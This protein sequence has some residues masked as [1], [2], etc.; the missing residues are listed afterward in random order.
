MND[1]RAGP[2]RRKTLRHP[3]GQQVGA[4]EPRKAKVPNPEHVRPGRA[5]A[6]TTNRRGENGNECRTEAEIRCLNAIP[7]DG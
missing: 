6:Q 7:T 4:L 1:W 5:F 3:A 2:R